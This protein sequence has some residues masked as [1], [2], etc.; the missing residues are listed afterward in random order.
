MIY[1]QTEA[2]EQIRSW[3]APCEIRFNKNSVTVTT[4]RRISDLKYSVES[5]LSQYSDDI[6]YRVEV[7]NENRFKIIDDDYAKEIKADW[8]GDFD[9]ESEKFAPMTFNTDNNK[10]EELQMEKLKQDIE[11]FVAVNAVAAL[12]ILEKTKDLAIM[13]EIQELMRFS[14]IN[15]LWANA[16]MKDIPLLQKLFNERY[17]EL[18]NLF[19]VGA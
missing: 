2:R 19:E 8:S 18:A 10:L 7:V 6:K 13:N 11:T 5:F 16:S 15:G 14:F 9:N 12:T 17:N 4:K 1:N 3:F